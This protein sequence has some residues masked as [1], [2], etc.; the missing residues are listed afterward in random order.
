MD[1]NYKL[2]KITIEG[3]SEFQPINPETG[4]EMGGVLFV[5]EDDKSEEQYA[6]YEN[7]G[8]DETPDWQEYSFWGDD[9][10]SAKQEYE[11][12]TKGE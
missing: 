4:K 3:R 8:T 6:I 7:L 2:V 1:D 11:E 10:D 12:L 9:F 5:C